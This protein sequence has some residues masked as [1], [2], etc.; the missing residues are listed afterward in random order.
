M[1]RIEFRCQNARSRERVYYALNYGPPMSF[2]SLLLHFGQLMLRGTLMVRS[3]NAGWSNAARYSLAI[4]VLH[5]TSEIPIPNSPSSKPLL[6]LNPGQVTHDVPRERLLLAPTHIR[7]GF[8]Q[9]RRKRRE[10]EVWCHSQIWTQHEPSG[11][12]GEGGGY[13]MGQVPLKGELKM[14]YEVRKGDFVSMIQDVR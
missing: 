13:G 4:K 3:R 2:N 14:H 12:P 5:T 6:I 8:A 1:N 9:L 7:Q 11:V 10:E